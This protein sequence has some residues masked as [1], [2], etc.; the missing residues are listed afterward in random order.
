MIRSSLLDRF[1]LEDSIEVYFVFFLSY[2]V[3]SMNFRTLH[4]FLELKQKKETKNAVHS[5]GPVFGP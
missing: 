4:N 1:A 3:F 2:I 5:V